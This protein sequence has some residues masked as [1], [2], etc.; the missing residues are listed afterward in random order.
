[1]RDEISD[2][3]K[4]LMDEWLAKKGNKI[5]VC[6]PMARSEPDDIGYTWGRKKKKAAPKKVDKASK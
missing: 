4:K 1:M 6:E 5:T 3:D 2:Q